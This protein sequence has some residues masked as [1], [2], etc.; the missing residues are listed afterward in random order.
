MLEPILKLFIITIISG[1]IGYERE[2]NRSNAGIK[3]HVLVGV[4]ATTVAL[5][6][7]GIVEMAIDSHI[8]IPDALG[9]VRA[10]PARL[11]AQ[12]VSGIGFLGA[13]TIIV[14]KRNI[15]G[16]TT[17]A[18]IWSVA[19]IGLAIGMGYYEVGIASFLFTILTL[20][21]FKRLVKIRVPERIVLKYLGGEKT[22]DLIETILSSMGLDFKIIKF[23]VEAFGDDLVYT[24]TLEID[25]KK[26][27]KFEKLVSKMAHTENVVSVE[28]TN[29]D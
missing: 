8:F 16:L 22:M 13:G 6:Q 2:V 4:G 29:F 21:V 11:I 12:V 10:D 24:N 20:F 28:R 19:C 17:A 1:F 25:S 15:S 9:A 5:I 18:S 3:T 26:K 7:L 23:N 14:T 27:L